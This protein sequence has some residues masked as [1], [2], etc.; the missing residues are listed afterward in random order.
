MTS[1]E[2]IK[3]WRIGFNKFQIADEY[4]KENN[5]EAEKRKDIEKISKIQA[6]AYIEPIIFKYTIKQFKN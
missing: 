2:I 6:L 5:D 1:E 3:K 4:M